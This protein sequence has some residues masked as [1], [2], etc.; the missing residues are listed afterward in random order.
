MFCFWSPRW[1]KR[2]SVGW[3]NTWM[4][5]CFRPWLTTQYPPEVEQ[6]CSTPISD[7]CVSVAGSWLESCGHKY[8]NQWSVTLCLRLQQEWTRQQTG[9]KEVRRAKKILFSQENGSGGRLETEFFFLVHPNEK[10]TFSDQYSI[11]GHRNLN[12]TEHSEIARYR[13][14]TQLKFVKSR[15]PF[16]YVSFFM[17]WPC[18]N[19]VFLFFFL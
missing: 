1:E 2:G 15:C 8:M 6:Q 12:R 7:S 16:S 9:I 19:C 14:L 13:N 11:D 5:K 4:L 10:N 18:S 17:Q 3:F